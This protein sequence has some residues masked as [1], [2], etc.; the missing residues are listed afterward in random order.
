MRRSSALVPVR[1]NGFSSD[2]YEITMA[3]TI[4]SDLGTVYQRTESIFAAPHDP[5]IDSRCLVA[6]GSPTH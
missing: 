5:R 4:V 1:V 6:L 2:G 3:V